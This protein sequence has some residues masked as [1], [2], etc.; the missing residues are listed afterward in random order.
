MTEREAQQT[1]DVERLR[2]LRYALSSPP[3]VRREIADVVQ[4]QK[5]QS[6][7]EGPVSPVHVI[8]VNPT[9]KKPRSE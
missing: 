5:Q 2:E 1:K 7:E 4:A 8:V 9:N 6:K 3:Q